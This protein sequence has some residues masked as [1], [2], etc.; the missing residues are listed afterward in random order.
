VNNYAML[1]LEVFAIRDNESIRIVQTRP[2]RGRWIAVM[3]RS[4]EMPDGPRSPVRESDG[5]PVEQAAILACEFGER[6]QS[7]H[8]QQLSPASKEIIGDVL[9]DNQCEKDRWY[10]LVVSDLHSPAALPAE[11]GK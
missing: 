7:W 9:F 4:I 3:A 5:A 10:F 6:Q 1:D 8:W 2:E 11:E